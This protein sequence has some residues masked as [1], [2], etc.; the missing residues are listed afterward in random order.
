MKNIENI[1]EK[2]QYITY[3]YDTLEE[4]KEHIEKMELEGYEHLENFDHV[5][6]VTYRKFL[7]HI[8]PN[9]TEV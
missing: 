9:M 7:D 3:T 5:W 2:V 1:I 6:Q 4:K 8:K